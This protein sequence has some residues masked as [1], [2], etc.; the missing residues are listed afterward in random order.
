MSRMSR[1]VQAVLLE[2][3][4]RLKEL[5]I[6]SSL[7][8]T[9]FLVSHE[10]YLHRRPYHQRSQA[11]Q[12]LFASFCHSSPVLCEQPRPSLHVQNVRTRLNAL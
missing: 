11:G 8:F 1:P 3:Q 12:Q 7:Q 9:C 10:R 4:D 6:D 2:Q 5:H